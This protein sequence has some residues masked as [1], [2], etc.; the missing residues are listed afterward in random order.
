MNIQSQCHSLKPQCMRYISSRILYDSPKLPSQ[1]CIVIVLYTM[2]CYEGKPTQINSLSFTCTSRHFM[3]FP[4]ATGCPGGEIF[5]SGS[6]YPST[7]RGLPD[8]EL[9][10]SLLR[11]YHMSY[12]VCVVHGMEG[13]SGNV[14]YPRMMLQRL[15][16][17]SQQLNL[18]EQITQYILIENRMF[19]PRS[20]SSAV[21][22]TTQECMYIYDLSQS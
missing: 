7:N 17:M 18:F 16:T 1:Q 2:H 4:F 3:P 11:D 8:S 21:R 19:R 12:I 10:V 14:V 6:R 9:G 22:L 5:T 13:N 20:P 15:T